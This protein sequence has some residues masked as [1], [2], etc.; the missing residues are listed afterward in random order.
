L[1]PDLGDARVASAD[2]TQFQHRIGNAMNDTKTFNA[3]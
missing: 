1:S 2:A 3:I